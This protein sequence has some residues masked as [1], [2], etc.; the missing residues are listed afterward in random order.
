MHLWSLLDCIRK[1]HPCRNFT[2]VSWLYYSG[3]SSFAS[4]NL[5]MIWYISF[6]YM[7]V[8]FT[9]CYRL[10]HTMQNNLMAWIWHVTA[11]NENDP[12]VDIHPVSDTALVC[13]HPAY[14]ELRFVASIQYQWRSH[15]AYVIEDNAAWNQNTPMCRQTSWWSFKVSPPHSHS[16]SWLHFLMFTISR[17]TTTVMHG[18]AQVL[19]G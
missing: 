10:Q 3:F 8:I 7:S 1:T 16:D 9:W 12:A 17:S 5:A 2:H 4:S 6:I 11:N 13:F 19:C 15:N 14:R 18:K